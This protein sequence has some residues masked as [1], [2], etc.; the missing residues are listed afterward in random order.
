MLTS[1]E[2]RLE[3][4]FE[5]IELMPADKVERAERLKDKERRQRL[6]EEKM[7]AQRLIQ[8]ERIQRALERAR[9]PV[10]KKTGKPVMFRSAPPQKKKKRTQDNKNKEEGTSLGSI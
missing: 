1:I 8:E 6:R 5:A 4:L 9:A 7:D 2:N 3:Q 10:K